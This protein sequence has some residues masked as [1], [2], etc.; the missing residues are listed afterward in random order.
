M[1]EVLDLE[2]MTLEEVNR[3][4]RNLVSSLEQADEAVLLEIVSSLEQA[5]EA[6]LLEIVSSLEQADEA[7]LLEI[8]DSL[9]ADEGVEFKEDFIQRC[10][11]FHDAEVAAPD[12]QDTGTVQAVNAWASEKTRGKIDEIIDKVDEDVVLMLLNAIYFDGEWQVPFDASLTAGDD[13]HL[14]KGGTATVPFM[15][16]S[17]ELQY[18]GN[19]D[20]QAVS[21]PYGGESTGRLSMCV[22]LPREGA[23]YGEFLAVLSA[24]DWES[25]VGGFASREGTLALP[26]FKVEYEKELSGA[27]KAM[28]M[29]PAFTGGFEGMAPGGGDFLFISKVLQKT[30]IDVDEEGTEAAAVTDVEIALS[31][32]LGPEP[33]SVTVDRPFFFAIRDNATGSLLFLGSI[34]DPSWNKRPRCYPPREMPRGHRRAAR[35]RQTGG[36]G[37]RKGSFSIVPGR[38]KVE[39]S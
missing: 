35:C 1:A 8:A 6:I 38:N 33:F 20:L 13:F 22:V 30:C 39:Y 37:C 24:E 12:L 28:D 7:A 14:P 25:W 2:G 36:P 5:D 15:H 17:Y 29:G 32:G 9:W 21:L 23:D 27:L 3:Q 31:V 16:R 18:F 4:L 34:A 19:E 11:D 10:H 26:R